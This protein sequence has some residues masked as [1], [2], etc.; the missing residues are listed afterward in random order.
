[1][2]YIYEDRLDK[3]QVVTAMTK[4]YSM[5]KEQRKILG[6]AGRQHVMDNYNFYDF[7]KTWVDYMDKICNEDR[8]YNNILFKEVA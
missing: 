5:S 6:E 4:I 1:M 2:P 8:N 7:Q 3:N